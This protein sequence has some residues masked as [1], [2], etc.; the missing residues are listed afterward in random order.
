M[1]RDLGAGVWYKITLTQ[2]ACCVMLKDGFLVAS[3]A[4]MI[5]FGFVGVGLGGLFSNTDSRLVLSVSETFSGLSDIRD[6]VKNTSSYIAGPNPASITHVGFPR[7]FQTIEE[8]QDMQRRGLLSSAQ[9]SSISINSTVSTSLL[10]RLMLMSWCSSGVSLPGVIP[11]LRTSGCK[12]IADVYQS[13]I[14]ETRPLSATNLTVVNVSLEVRE[15]LGN[16][17]Y[18]C[19]DQ[20]QVTRARSCG[21]V[22]TTH[23]VGLGVFSNV[24]MFLVCAAFLLAVNLEHGRMLVKLAVV[25][26]GVAFASIFIVKDAEANVLN[27]VGILLS[28]FLLIWGLDEELNMD[29]PVKVLDDFNQIPNIPHPL[30]VC[31]VVNLPLML[32]AHTYQ[33][34][35]SGYGRDLW[36]V[37]SFGVCGGILGALLQVRGLPVP[38]HCV[39]GLISCFFFYVRSATSGC[40]G[41]ARRK[42]TRSWG[43][44]RSW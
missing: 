37:A 2:R 4:A 7:T 20:R 43:G 25:L 16:R 34:S 1:Y 33:L 19:W 23:V 32:S 21:R 40:A 6:V 9:L 18:R 27:M 42:R 12:C 24:V 5:S 14:N 35:V 44:W 13:L 38:F 22:C 29:S 8:Y 11:A 15:R 17:V 41:T 26:M 10:E 36:V 31:V 39:S 3:V 28:V 30:I